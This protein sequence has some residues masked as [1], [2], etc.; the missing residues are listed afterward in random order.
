MHTAHEMVMEM[1]VIKIGII[2]IMTRIIIC[3]LI[4]NTMQGLRL[5]KEETTAKS[6]HTHTHIPSSR[7]SYHQEH[8][9]T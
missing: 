6:A 9:R 5:Q 8:K 4:F 3:H 7:R 2:I 1:I